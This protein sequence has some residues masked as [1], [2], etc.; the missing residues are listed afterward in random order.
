M[1]DQILSNSIVETISIPKRYFRV[2]STLNNKVDATDTHGNR[3]LL[4]LSEITL[5]DDP[6]KW[7]ELDEIFNPQP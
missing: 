5:I 3:E 1:E 7:Q 6:I 4:A 2:T